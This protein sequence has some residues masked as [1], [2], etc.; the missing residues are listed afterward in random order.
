[1][2]DDLGNILLGADYSVGALLTRPQIIDVQTGERLQQLRARVGQKLFS[3]AVKDNYDYRCC[4]PH[5]PISDED[6]LIGAHIARWADNPE[7]RGSLTNG[8]CL[9][10]MHDR[11]FEIG[12]FTI[13]KDLRV[14]LNDE[15][16]ATLTSPW[17][18]QNIVPHN[19]KTIR[20]GAILPTEQALLYH[21]ERI[22]F[23]P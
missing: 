9:C 1:V 7:L 20:C 13:S 17:C 19:G 11:A 3:D 5:C 4:F 16:S 15:R 10:L 8:L 23:K 18:Q 22:G 14:V 2:D 12:L 6:F 21:W